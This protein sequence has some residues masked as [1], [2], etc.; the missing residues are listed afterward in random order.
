MDIF[1]YLQSDGF[2]RSWILPRA[3]WWK[4][5]NY[6]QVVPGN[7]MGKLIHTF[8]SFIWGLLS[9]Q[10]DGL[11][12][13]FRGPRLEVAGLFQTAPWGATSKCPFWQGFIFG[14]INQKHSN[15][16]KNVDIFLGLYP[17]IF[18]PYSE[19]PGSLAGAPR[20][21]HSQKSHGWSKSYWMGM[22]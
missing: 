20:C 22:A 17:R 2:V 3:A 7:K 12:H 6:L 8:P 9:L 16:P 4:S 18:L 10:L 5:W 1:A 19:L 13:Q 14:Q 11:T 15:K 21:Q